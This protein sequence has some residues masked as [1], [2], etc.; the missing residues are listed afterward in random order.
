MD[1]LDFCNEFKCKIICYNLL[2][3][4]LCRLIY[5]DHLQF[6]CIYSLVF[7]HFLYKSIYSS[8]FL[9]FCLSSILKIVFLLF[10]LFM[11]CLDWQFLNFT[12]S[13]L[14]FVF[15][16]MYTGAFQTLRLY[17]YLFSSGS[18]CGYFVCYCISGVSLNVRYHGGI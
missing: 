17:S 11:A 12:L 15:I 14:L 13:N 9:S 5:I 10:I 18:L 6:F 2:C 1:S 8:A 3:L 7:V 4:L 16:G